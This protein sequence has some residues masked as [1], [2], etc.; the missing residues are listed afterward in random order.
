MDIRAKLNE[1]DN[2]RQ[3]IFTNTD[4]SA[5]G[6]DKELAKLNA[7]AATY[8]SEVV[9][10][11]RGKWDGWKAD[12]RH[13]VEALR[14]ANERAAAGW[15][16]ARL[17]YMEKAVNFRVG[18]AD[19]F[20][21]VAGE[22]QRVKESGD[23]HAWRAWVE[24]AGGT[25]RVK[26]GNDPEAL[27]FVKR[28]SQ[29][30]PEVLETDEVKE[31]KA[32]GERLSKQAQELDEQTE[33]ARAFY[34]PNGSGILGVKDDFETLRDGVQITRRVVPETLATVTSVRLKD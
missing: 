25:I 3:G 18:G 12:A 28:L 20:A 6:R 21:D 17:N 16:Y 1:F 13:N 24:T 32:E 23:R 15:D 14:E 31:L 29:D 2:R 10:E 30:A 7:E 34:H 8:K 26:F 4:L 19:S 33:Q 5:Q 27:S 22:Y 11:L 9:R